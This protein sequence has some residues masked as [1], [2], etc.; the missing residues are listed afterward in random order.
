M[1]HISQKLLKRLPP[2][3]G[4][5]PRLNFSTQ[6]A[7]APVEEE[8]KAEKVDPY[9]VPDFPIKKRRKHRALQPPKSDDRELEQQ[10]LPKINPEDLIY[11]LEEGADDSEFG[12]I[13]TFTPNEE[14]G[15]PPEEEVLRRARMIPAKTI[16]INVE[17]RT[18]NLQRYMLK[19]AHIIY[20]RRPQY[21]HYRAMN[22]PMSRQL[23]SFPRYMEE[24]TFD[25]PEDSE[26]QRKYITALL[27]KIRRQ[28]GR[29]FRVPSAK[30]S[31]LSD[32]PN[33]APK[34]VIGKCVFRMTKDEQRNDMFQYRKQIE[35]IVYNVNEAFSDRN[36]DIISTRDFRFL[37]S[38]PEFL[39]YCHVFFNMEFF[40]ANTYLIGNLDVEDICKNALT[41]H[42]FYKHLEVS[43]L[44]NIISIIWINS[45]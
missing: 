4:K 14:Q 33:K 40:Q 26:G 30:I 20:Q 37:L 24:E 5:F 31:G 11:S 32:L 41:N 35:R 44:F 12:I 36:F 28:D 10:N 39:P 15:E 22:R 25:L 13:P 6:E 19:M 38:N 27:Q 2:C 1:I 8:K 7:P 42:D 43:S 18:A 29:I 21:F 16:K 45:D 9:K 34:T 17:N 23:R 3:L